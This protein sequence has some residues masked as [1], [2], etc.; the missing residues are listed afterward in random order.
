V[1]APRMAWRR[2]SR[3]SWLRARWNVMKLILQTVGPLC[4]DRWSVIV[5][6]EITDRWSEMSGV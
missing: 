3:C 6:D 2:A 1:A 4:V 5:V